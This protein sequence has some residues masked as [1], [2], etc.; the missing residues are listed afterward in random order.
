MGRTEPVV[1][2]WIGE[3]MIHTVKNDHLKAFM[4]KM[5]SEGLPS[6]VMETFAYYYDKVLKGE[7]GLVYDRDIRPVSSD[8]IESY[9]NLLSYGRIGIDVFPQ[10]VRIILN[11]GLG[12]S[13]GLTGPKSLIEIK[14]GMSFL[15]II[16]RQAENSEV[17][18][19]FMNS[20]NTQA[21]CEST[22]APTP[23]TTAPRTMQP[24]SRA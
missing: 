11:G 1:L 17:V 22:A 5:E 3:L 14:D 12:T 21:T 2:F 18:L 9:R 16:M 23:S 24:R 4:S 15:D 6:L 10:T 19:A 8:E 7:T 20:F 13:M